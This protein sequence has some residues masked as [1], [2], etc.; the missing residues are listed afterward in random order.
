MDAMLKWLDKVPQNLVDIIAKISLTLVIGVIIIRGLHFILDRSLFKKISEHNRLLVKSFITYSG[1]VI[2]LFFILSEAGVNLA[3]LFG[4]AGI[5]GIA[6][7]FASQT[8]VANIISGLFLLSE[9]PFAVGD[10]IRVGDKTG[11]I[12]SF[13]LLSIKIRTFDNL[14]I[15]LPNQMVLNTDV[16][17]VTRFPIRRMDMVFTVAYGE[18]LARLRTLLLEVIQANKVAL[19][20]PEPLV[21]LLGLGSMG[22]DIQLGVWFVKTDFVALKNSLIPEIAKRFAA[23]GIRIPVGLR[24]VY[25]GAELQ[26]LPLSLEEG[27]SGNE[28]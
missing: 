5:L 13:D 19:N 1:I 18:D 16:T 10:I 12:L 28:H 14:F 26:P 15:R 9:K 4:A 23:E 24:A 21:L 20:E 17:N 2:I 7:G 27:E 6:L 11:V 25:K 3:T 22:I 8:S